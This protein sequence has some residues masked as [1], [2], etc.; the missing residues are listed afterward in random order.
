M[1]SKSYYEFDKWVNLEIR[2][3]LL[4]KINGHATQNGMIPFRADLIDL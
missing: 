2:Y 3:T 4:H 1:A